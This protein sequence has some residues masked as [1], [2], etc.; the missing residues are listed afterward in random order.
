MTN[1]S[2]EQVTRNLKAS[3]KKRKIDSFRI[4]QDLSIHHNPSK[5]PRKNLNKKRKGKVHEEKILDCDI[6]SKTFKTNCTLKKHIKSVHE[7]KTFKCYICQSAL[8]NKCHLRTH[9]ES[10]HKGKTYK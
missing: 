4:E 6:R 8:T 7:G 2:T 1:K 5:K 10:V 9:I 3:G